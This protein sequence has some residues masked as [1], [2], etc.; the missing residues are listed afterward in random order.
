MK[1]DLSTFAGRQTIIAVSNVAID[2]TEPRPLIGCHRLS[3]LVEISLK[4][5]SK[6]IDADNILIQL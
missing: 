5:G 4:A 6:V 3:D 1:N 2:K